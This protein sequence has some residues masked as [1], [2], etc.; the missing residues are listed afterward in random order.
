MIDH[1][2]MRLPRKILVSIVLVAIGA[3]AVS[4]G[5]PD[6]SWSSDASIVYRGNTQSHI[7]HRSSCRHFGCKNCTRVFSSREEAINA[8]YRPCKVCNP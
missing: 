1:S 8:G 4:A 5:L 6:G 7:F 3:M 2:L